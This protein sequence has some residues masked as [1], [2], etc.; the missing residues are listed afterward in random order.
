MRFLDIFQVLAESS[1]GRKNTRVICSE[2][3]PKQ[4]PTVV[5]DHINSWKHQLVRAP[6]RSRQFL[7]LDES[8]FQKQVLYFPALT[9]SNSVTAKNPLV[10]HISTALAKKIYPNND[11]FIF[12]FE[13][14][15]HSTAYFLSLRIKRCLHFL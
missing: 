4:G 6:E 3:C 9:A 8:G 12:Q 11:L 2:I 1:F 5:E 15:T 7:E 10:L 14:W 13:I